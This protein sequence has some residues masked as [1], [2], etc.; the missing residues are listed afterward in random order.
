MPSLI[1]RSQSNNAWLEARTRWTKSEQAVNDFR[2]SNKQ[3]GQAARRAFFVILNSGRV[4]RGE[5]E[6]WQAQHAAIVAETDRPHVDRTAPRIRSCCPCSRRSLPLGQDHDELVCMIRAELSA[7]HLARSDCSAACFSIA[8][9]PTL[10]AASKSVGFS[11]L[12][13]ISKTDGACDGYALATVQTGP[14]EDE[15]P[16]SGAPDPFSPYSA[17]SWRTVCD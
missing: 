12:R 13:R 9:S 15:T 17:S 16:G 11:R 7:G 6:Q 8:W 5:R 14:I 2:P 10:L 4:R 1:R 3:S